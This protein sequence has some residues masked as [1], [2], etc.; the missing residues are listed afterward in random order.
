MLKKNGN[1]QANPIEVVATPIVSCPCSHKTWKVQLN[2]GRI[3]QTV[4]N[5]IYLLHISRLYK[6]TYHRN[7]QCHLHYTDVNTNINV[8]II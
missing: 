5:Y 4:Q 8:N 3:V 7:C 1:N 6:M 2:I